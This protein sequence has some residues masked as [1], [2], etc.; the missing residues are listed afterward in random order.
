[1]AETTRRPASPAALHRAVHVDTRIVV[2]IAELEVGLAI[3]PAL[4]ERLGLR[5]GLGEVVGQLRYHLGILRGAIKDM[6]DDPYPQQ[7]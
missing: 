3:D 2:A 6:C 4:L 5:V 7:P 1:M